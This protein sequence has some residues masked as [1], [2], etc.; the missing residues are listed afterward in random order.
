MAT[1]DGGVGVG[2]GV[3]LHAAVHAAPFPSTAVNAGSGSRRSD[4]SCSSGNRFHSSGSSR[5]RHLSS[6]G[7]TIMGQAEQRVR[8]GARA[9][10]AS[11]GGG[12][13]STM[14][15]DVLRWVDSSTYVILFLANLRPCLTLC[16]SPCASLCTRV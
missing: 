11:N 16:F 5:P 14:S 4:S 6:T 7:G 2:G 1:S 3:E 15:S 13:V 12:G 8:G 9:G 10:G